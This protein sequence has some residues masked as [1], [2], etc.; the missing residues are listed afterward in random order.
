MSG[1]EP[2][3]RLLTAAEREEQRFGVHVPDPFAPAP[4]AKPRVMQ[5]RALGIAILALSAVAAG[6]ALLILLPGGISAIA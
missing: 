1:R 2:F 6:L 5:K 4:K 3:E